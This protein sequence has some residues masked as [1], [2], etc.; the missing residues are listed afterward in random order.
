[1]SA[2]LAT[3][4]EDVQRL[5]LA[6]RGA[7]N[8]YLLDDLLVD[9]GLPGQ[10]AAIVR[11]LGPRPVARHVLTHPHLDHAGGSARA[12]RAFGLEGVAC[13][14]ADLADLRAGRSPDWRC[15]RGCSR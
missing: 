2:L 10:G 9:A 11:M 4:V 12:C 6:P 8:A 14:A 15:D 5:A 7:L 13:G 1:M 3:P